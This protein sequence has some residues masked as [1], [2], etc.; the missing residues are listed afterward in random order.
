MR[1][2][3]RPG[4]SIVHRT[5]GGVKIALLAGAALLLALLPL[6]AVGV[7]GV[8]VLVSLLYPLARLPV[9]A[10]GAAWW[11]LRWIVV[12]VGGALGLLVSWETA[13]VSTGRVV[14]LMLLAELVTATTT[15]A[16]V[17]EVLRSVLTPFRAMGVDPDAAALVLALTIA[18][19][20]VVSGFVQQTRD[21][22]RARG[23]RMGPRGAVPI[24]VRTLRHADAV[25][26]ALTARGLAP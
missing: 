18:T 13:A 16:A 11:R 6:S 12:V 14:A 2:L 1:Q 23:V 10:L 3:Y 5:P 8:L 21:A 24:L 4:R 7:G 25:G 20:P 22:H 17:T 26:E 9:S 15:M 19:V